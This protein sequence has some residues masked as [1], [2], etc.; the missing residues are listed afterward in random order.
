MKIK[1]DIR[2]GIDSVMMRFYTTYK[3]QYYEVV[4]S[5]KTDK[6]SVDAMMAQLNEE[7]ITFIRESN[8]EC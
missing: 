2:Y 4:N 5:S 3:G 6:E 7:L 1:S 8:N